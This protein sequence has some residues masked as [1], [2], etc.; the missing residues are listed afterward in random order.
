MRPADPVAKYADHDIAVLP[1]EL[2]PAEARALL[3]GVGVVVADGGGVLGTV[4]AAELQEAAA[5]VRNAV[6][7]V[8]TLGIR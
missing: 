2:T 6:G 3:T 7:S 1:A 5:A 4:T 8:L